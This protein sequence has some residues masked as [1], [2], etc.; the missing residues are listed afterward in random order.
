MGKETCTCK[1]SIGIDHPGVQIKNRG[2][3]AATPAM[4]EVGRQAIG[5]NLSSYIE[6]NN[7]SCQGESKIF[8]KIFSNF[9]IWKI[10]L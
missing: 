8:P 4:G 1:G 7:E 6:E 10:G 5:N 9:T 2:C 3:L